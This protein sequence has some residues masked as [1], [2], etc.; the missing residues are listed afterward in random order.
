MANR[1]PLMQVGLLISML[2]MCLLQ[3]ACVR[4]GK[5]VQGRIVDSETG[6]GLSG[7]IVMANWM[8]STLSGHGRTNLHVAETVTDEKGEYSLPKWIGVHAS[9]PARYSQPNILFLLDGY[10][11]VVM[12]NKIDTDQEGEDLLFEEKKQTV[13]L[14]KFRE[15]NKRY[16]AE[17]E[18][19]WGS[20]ALDYIAYGYD[21]EWKNVPLTMTTYHKISLRMDK[22]QIPHS[23]ERLQ[24]LGK[25][26]KCGNAVE[27]FKGYL[28]D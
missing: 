13:A 3:T 7:V 23:L 12:Q 22:L 1:K 19:V 18:H 20:V 27:Y 8:L 28:D 25:Q 24:R 2:L 14:K 10:H 4:F 15:S 26:K 6:E 21:C 17:L 11:P 9:R 5:E 16:I